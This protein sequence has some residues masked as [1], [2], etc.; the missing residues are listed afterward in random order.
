VLLALAALFPAAFRLDAI[1]FLAVSW[2][3]LNVSR[4][5]DELKWEAGSVGLNGFWAKPSAE[6]RRSQPRDLERKNRILKPSGELVRRNV[7]IAYIRLNFT[8][9]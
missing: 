8:N 2:L 7:S 4:L 1:Y 5:P 3:R 9:E 6:G